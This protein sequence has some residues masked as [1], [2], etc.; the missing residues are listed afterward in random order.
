M[1][2]KEWLARHFLATNAH[3]MPDGTL[4][5]ERREIFDD[6]TRIRDEWILIR[7][8]RART[9]RFHHTIYSGQELRDR[10]ERA[11]FVDIAVYGDQDGAPYD[12]QAKRVIIVGRKSA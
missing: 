6:W 11:G 4:M 12:R 2:S 10:L 3:E 8:G 1:I 5:V 7:D 9:F